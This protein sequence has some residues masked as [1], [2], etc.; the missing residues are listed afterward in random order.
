MK[1]SD[2]SMGLLVAKKH[3]TKARM[4]K[5]VACRCLSGLKL[6]FPQVSMAGSDN[7]QI[8]S[9]EHPT[10]YVRLALEYVTRMIN[11]FPG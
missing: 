4:L 5:I 2:L 1:F 8:V 7:S 10:G 6:A 11:S 9:D 3:Y